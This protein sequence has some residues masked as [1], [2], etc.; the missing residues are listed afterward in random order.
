[1][2]I[3]NI[4]TIQ[5]NIPTDIQSFPV[6]SNQIFEGIYDMAIREGVEI[7]KN[8]LEDKSLING[9]D[10]HQK[11]VFISKDFEVHLMISHI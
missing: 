6:E 3:L 1:L 11:G 10:F 2:R 5:K 9:D 8:L 4:L 7:I